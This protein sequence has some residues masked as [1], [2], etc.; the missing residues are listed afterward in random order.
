MAMFAI[1]CHPCVPVSPDELEQWLEQQVA[2]I[3][4]AAPQSAVRLLRLTQALPSGDV[5]VGWLL[6]LEFCESDRLPVL[7]RLA[8]AMR[9]MK[10]LGFQPRVL[11]PSPSIARGSRMVRAHQARAAT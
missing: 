5:D 9:D 7:D 1:R 10:L 4:A 8:E 11:A 3:R 6:E 2:D